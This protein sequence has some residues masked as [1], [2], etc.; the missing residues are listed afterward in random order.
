MGES[1]KNIPKKIPGAW[2]EVWI[3]TNFETKNNLYHIS[4]YGRIRSTSK[5]TGNES[6]IK[7]AYC[8]KQVL[9]NVI[10][11]DG[12]RGV[13]SVRKFVAEHFCERP[14]EQHI[15]VVNL[16]QDFTNNK[17][18]NLK[19]LTLEEWYEWNQQSDSYKEGRE[20]L[21]DI[22]KLNPTKVKLIKERLQSGKVKPKTIAKQFRVSLSTVNR[23]MNGKRWA[24]VELDEDK[25][26]GKNNK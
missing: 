17:W 22:Y 23:I 19:W 14:S 21:K 6:I 12:T 2:N 18:I 25:E 8:N 13:C 15:R 26:E 24:E 16:D 9:L 5:A 7:G 1:K 11:P 4:N 20:K 10:Q 3:N